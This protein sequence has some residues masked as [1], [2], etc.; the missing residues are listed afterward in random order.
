M[1]KP[2]L[3]EEDKEK[4][5]AIIYAAKQGDLGLMACTDTASGEYRAV[6][7]VRFNIREEDGGGVELVPIGHLCESDPYLMYSPF[8]EETM[9]IS[10]TK[11]PHAANYHINDIV[12]IIPMMLDEDDPRSTTE[13]LDSGYSHGGG[14]RPFKGFTLVKK[15]KDQPSTWYLSYPQDPPT[16]VMA[17]AKFRDDWILVCEYSWVCVVKPDGTYEVCRMD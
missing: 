2:R 5:N 10:F 14:W 15:D 9:M 7:V 11:T 4:L 8:K 3:R 1:T 13:Q 6:L 12:G 17:Y 16:H